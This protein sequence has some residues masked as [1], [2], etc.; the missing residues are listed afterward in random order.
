MHSVLSGIQAHLDSR[1]RL[2][3]DFGGSIRAEFLGHQRH[4]F[5]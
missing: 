4:V 2:P 5:F 1:L 3:F